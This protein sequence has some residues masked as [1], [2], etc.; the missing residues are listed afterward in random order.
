MAARMNDTLAGSLRGLGSA[1]ERVVVSVGTLFIPAVRGA[2]D[3]MTGFLR[4]LDK[5]AQTPFGAALLKIVSAVSL[6]VVALTG[7]SAAIWFFSS[8][9]PMLAKALAPAKAALL[10]LGAPVYAVIAVLGLLYAAY[11]TNFGGMADYLHECWNKI[12][13]TVR[14][15]LSVFRTLKDGSGE[16]SGHGAGKADLGF[17]AGSGRGTRSRGQKGTLA[18]WHSASALSRRA[19]RGRRGGFQVRGLRRMDY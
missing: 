12:T 6:A 2:V 11:R 3:G 10:G 15:V 17:Q 5:A 16:I 18:V 19:G 14:G 7:L 9:G 4:L 1:W 13:L 8:V